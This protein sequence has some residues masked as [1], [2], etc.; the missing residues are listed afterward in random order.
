MELMVEH[1]AQMM[2]FFEWLGQQ[3]PQYAL[4]VE[5]AR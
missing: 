2:I 1:A 5:L 3:V 4:Q